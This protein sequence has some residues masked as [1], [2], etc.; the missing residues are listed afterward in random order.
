MQHPTPDQILAGLKTV[1]TRGYALP[2]K[3]RGVRVAMI[4]TR[5][6]TGGP[7]RPR[8]V[9]LLTFTRAYQYKDRDQW[10]GDARLH[11]VPSNDPD[12]GWPQ[13]S[14]KWAWCIT[15]VERIRPAE[16]PRNAQDNPG[17][18]FVNW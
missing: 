18:S 4:E 7:I 11:L 6:R 8:I 10:M 5:G 1:E 14:Q 15:E 17:T 13:T 9:G 16:V 12:F 2:A 3:F